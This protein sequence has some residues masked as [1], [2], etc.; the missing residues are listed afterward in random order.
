M[1]KSEALETALNYKLL[2][3]HEHLK[4]CVFSDTPLYANES[5]WTPVVAQDWEERAE[6]LRAEWAGSGVTVRL[7]KVGW[8]G[9]ELSREAI[10]SVLQQ[11]LEPIGAVAGN[12]GV[13][14]ELFDNRG[15]RANGG[16]EVLGYGG[17]IYVPVVMRDLSIVCSPEQEA[18]YLSLWG[19]AA[20]SVRGADTR[21][22]SEAVGLPSR[23]FHGGCAN[24]A[25]GGGDG[26]AQSVHPDELVDSGVPAGA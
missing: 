4:K 26:A 24:E 11:V 3:S 5:D 21:E 7:F 1:G 12:I 19:G 2:S 20:C 10:V 8:Q 9:R 6:G 17:D 13:Y 18:R 15:V 25:E 14:S 16:K 22:C 23:L